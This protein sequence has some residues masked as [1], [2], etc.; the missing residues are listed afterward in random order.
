MNH[1]MSCIFRSRYVYSTSLPRDLNMDPDI[2]VS[3]C[4]ASRCKLLF[5][6]RGF[7]MQALSFVS[8][9]LAHL[10]RFHT[11]RSEE[12]CVTCQKCASSDVIT[13]SFNNLSAEQ[14]AALH[15]LEAV[16]LQHWQRSNNVYYTHTLES[17]SDWLNVPAFCST[18]EL[19]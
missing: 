6:H 7:T 11:C 1:P 12:K 19:H 16:A 10:S 15:F 17:C 14:R 8:V 2:S 18:V 9:N 4:V 5:S 3:F 13:V